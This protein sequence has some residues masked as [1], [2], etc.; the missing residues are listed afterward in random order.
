MK[1]KMEFPFSHLFASSGLPYRL[2]RR[3]RKQES[4]AASHL[5]LGLPPVHHQGWMM[6]VEQ[7]KRQDFWCER[8]TG[9]SGE[10]PEG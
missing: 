2:H 9:F 5:F 1:K 7:A 4:A 8:H 3:G 6:A 10:I